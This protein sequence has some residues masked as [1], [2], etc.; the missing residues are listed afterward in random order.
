MAL[1]LDAQPRRIIPSTSRK[2]FGMNLNL[3][4]LRWLEPTG[5]DQARQRRG[6][7]R[8]LQSL[9]LP[10][11]GRREG[12]GCLGG[13]GCVRLLR[14]HLLVARVLLLLLLDDLVTHCPLSIARASPTSDRRSLYLPSH[15]RRRPSF[16]RK[17]SNGSSDLPGTVQITVA[18]NLRGLSEARIAM[19]AWN[20]CLNRAW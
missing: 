5:S 10:W 17:L 4:K 11:L 7:R 8:S 1:G 3:S 6:S 18:R 13:S 2:M 20:T 14:K 15:P 9:L 12:G 16:R 19:S